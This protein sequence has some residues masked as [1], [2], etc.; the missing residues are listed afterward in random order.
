MVNSTAMSIIFHFKQGTL[1]KCP[2]LGLG[3]K[4]INVQMSLVRTPHSR[5]QGYYQ[6]TTQILSKELRSN[7]DVP[8]REIGQFENQ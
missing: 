2:I 3:Q 6:K 8:A 5:E 7:L 1:E 4:K